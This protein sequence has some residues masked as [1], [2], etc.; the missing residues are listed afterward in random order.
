MLRTVEGTTRIGRVY[1][2]YLVFLGFFGGFFFTR[3][4]ENLNLHHSYH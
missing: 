2:R 1:L 4:M 3:L